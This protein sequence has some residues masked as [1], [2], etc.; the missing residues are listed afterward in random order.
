VSQAT[1]W[2]KNERIRGLCSP[3]YAASVAFNVFFWSIEEA[4]RDDIRLF[5]LR[6]AVRLGYDF[7]LMKNFATVAH[8]VTRVARTADASW[9]VHGFMHLL[10]ATEA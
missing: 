2:K 4:R 8:Y 7:G 1:S 10:I 9:R 5:G 3:E 6:T